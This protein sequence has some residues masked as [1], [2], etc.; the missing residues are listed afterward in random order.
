MSQT[1]RIQANVNKEVAIQAEM[2]IN[3]LGLTPTA[4]INSLYKKIAATGEIPFSFKLTPDQLADLELKELVKKI[5]EEKIRSKQ[6]LED[7]FDED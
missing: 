7:F 4:V 1:K 3:E 5:P 6:E 2:I